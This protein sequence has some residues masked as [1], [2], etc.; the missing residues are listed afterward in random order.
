MNMYRDFPEDFIWGSATA[1]YQ[2]EG[3]PFEDGKGASVWNEF[4]KRP[5]AMRDDVNG[6][7]ACDHY[8]RYPEDIAHMKN[9]GLNGYR[10][11]LAWRRTRFP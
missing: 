1:S 5:G 11:S 10:F 6:N 4:E 3:A 7:V 2:V 8:H 9:I